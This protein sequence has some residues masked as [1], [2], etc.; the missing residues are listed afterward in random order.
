M[1]FKIDIGRKADGEIDG[2]KRDHDQ[3]QDHVGSSNA[4]RWMIPAN[5]RVIGKSRHGREQGCH[6][7]KRNGVKRREHE[8][9][10]VWKNEIG[11]VEQQTQKEKTDREMDEHRMD[12]MLERFAFEKIFQHVDLTP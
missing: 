2:V 11:D 8:V 7:T 1:N 5:I 3:V 10:H 6:D 4:F 9:W 12:R